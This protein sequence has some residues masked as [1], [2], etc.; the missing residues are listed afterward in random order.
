MTVE[1][2]YVP[3]PKSF[4]EDTWETIAENTSSNVYNVGDTRRVLIDNKPYTVRIANKSTPPECNDSNF[5]QTACGFVVE[6]ADIVEKRR[7]N[8][9]NTNVGGWEA[10]EMRTYA[11]N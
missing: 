11:I 8:P 2:N 4:A 6:F 9:T 7:M 10:S 1:D 3:Q 5:S